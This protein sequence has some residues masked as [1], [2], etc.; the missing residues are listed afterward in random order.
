MS[1]SSIWLMDRTISDASTLGQSGPGSNDNKEVLHFPQSSS[2]WSLT[3]RL[4]NVMFRTLITGVLALSRD[5]VGVFYNPSQLDCK[6]NKNLIVTITWLNKDNCNNL[7][8]TI[9]WLNKDKWRCKLST[10]KKGI[11]VTIFYLQKHILSVYIA[12]VVQAVTH[13]GLSQFLLWPR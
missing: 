3:I 2:D 13:D 10:S 7:I 1:K 11:L 9:T 8:V 5:V 6:A 12:F 4:F